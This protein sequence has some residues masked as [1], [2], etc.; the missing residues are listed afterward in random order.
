MSGGVRA[1]LPPGC[2]LDQRVRTDF[3]DDDQ[4]DLIAMQPFTILR[5]AEKKAFGFSSQLQASAEEMVQRMDIGVH[6][7]DTPPGLSC[8]GLRGSSPFANIEAVDR[9][10]IVLRTTLL[11]DFGHIVYLIYDAVNGSL[12]VIPTPQNPSW[13]FTGLTN[14]ILIQRP[15]YCHDYA[16]VLAGKLHVTYGGQDQD[17]LLLWRPISSSSPPWSEVK[18]AMFPN[19]SLIDMSMFQADMAFSVNGISYWADLLRGVTY[20]LCDALFNNE[21]DDDPVVK[22]GFFPLPGELPG[23]D[24]RRSNTR[25]AQPKAYRNMGVV[26]D[27]II[28]FISIDGVL[29]HVELKDRTLTVWRL[30]DHDMGWKK[31][32]ELRV[33]T[34]WGLDGFGD[35]PKDITPMYPLLSTEDHDV[36]YFAL[37]EY[38]ENSEKQRNRKFIP[39]QAHYL[40]AVNLQNKTI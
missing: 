28:K 9:G 11:H 40:L 15:R 12:H 13:G 29:E 10:T 37:G 8:L 7:A 22:F 27:S 34:L 30:L 4:E 26:R 39:T 21:G 5:C 2:V 18:K 33:E 25:V 36:V 38:R 24:H 16:L 23:A 32:Y 35:I 1:T 17:A 6:L 14:R 19:K 3:N 31:E 20:C